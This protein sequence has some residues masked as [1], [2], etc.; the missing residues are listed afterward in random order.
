MAANRKPPTR[1]NAK[2]EQQREQDAFSAIELLKEDHREVQAF[3]EKYEQTEGDAEKDALALKICLALLV[4]A[5][6]EEEIFYPEARKAISKP[7]LIDEAIV[8]HAAAK[9][10][11]AEIEAMEVGDR[12]RDAEVKVLGEQITHH[13][14]EEEGELFPAVEAAGLD[15]NAL[16]QRISAR[17]AELLKQLADEGEIR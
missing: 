6:V 14:E 8:E 4:H 11:V 15:V 2:Q 5:Q 16:G 9:Q 7:E 3:F 13:V 17:K 10:L 1:R 12:M